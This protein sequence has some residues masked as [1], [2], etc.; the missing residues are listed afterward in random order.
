M[1]EKFDL[2]KMLQEIKDDEIPT[3]QKARQASQVDIK[4]LLE[5]K[6]TSS[7][8]RNVDKS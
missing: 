4:R 6:R 5:R 3:E 8:D 2:N 7:G 1:S